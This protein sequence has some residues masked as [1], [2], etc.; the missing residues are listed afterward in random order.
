MKYLTERSKMDVD[1]D[2]IFPKILS[3]NYSNIIRPRGEAMIK[4]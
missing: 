3:Y 4:T 2:P 1:N